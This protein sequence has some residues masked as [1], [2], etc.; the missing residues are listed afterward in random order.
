MFSGLIWYLL[1]V[2][3]S[4][5]YGLSSI[6]PPNSNLGIFPIIFVLC[7]TYPSS[8][9]SSTSILY[10]FSLSSYNTTFVPVIFLIFNFV[11]LLSERCF[12]LLFVSTFFI[13]SDFTSI[14]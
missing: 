1:Y 6:S 3:T 4:I 8:V 10:T 5:T 12:S 9:I 2:S 11:F 14:A 13:L 7:N